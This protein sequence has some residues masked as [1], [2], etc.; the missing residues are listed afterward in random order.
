[1]SFDTPSGR[2]H[3]AIDPLARHRCLAAAAAAD[4]CLPAVVLSLLYVPQSP[5]IAFRHSLLV[6]HSSGRRPHHQSLLL[7]HQVIN[8]L[9]I[10]SSRPLSRLLIDS[11]SIDRLLRTLARPRRAQFIMKIAAAVSFNQSIQFMNAIL[12]LLTAAVLL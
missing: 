9:G 12:L 2:P 10:S 3:D 5:L 11:S 1:V 4:V 7:L 8:H 6:A